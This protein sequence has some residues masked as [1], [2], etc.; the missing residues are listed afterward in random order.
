MSDLLQTGLAWLASQLKQHA[1]RP[2]TYVRG[3]DS[4][5]VQATPAKTEF[6]QSDTHGF[7]TDSEIRDFLIATADLVLAGVTV[8]P[9]R[10]D[11]IRDTDG[12]TV[13]VFEVVPVGN[14]PHWR[15]S[16]PYRNLLRIHVREIDS[17]AA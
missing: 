12:Q 7:K 5:V 1:S 9:E 8:L 3:N 14:E 6:E 15:Y 17:E 4:A 13:H 16:D 2:V 10:G 11:L